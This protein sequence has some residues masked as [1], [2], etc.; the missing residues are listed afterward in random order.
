MQARPLPPYAGTAPEEDALHHGG[1]AQ[2]ARRRFPAGLEQP[3]DSFRFSVDALLLA[4]FA[5]RPSSYDAEHFV[6]LGTGCGVVS[7]AFLLLSENNTYGYGIDHDETL[8]AAAA[9]NAERLGL[10]KRF[11]PFHA[12]L[13]DKAALRTLRN[14]Q[15]TAD[16]VMA[17]PPWRLLGAG[18][19]PA[20]AARRAA[21]FGDAGTFPLFAEAASALLRQGGGFVCVVGAYRVADLFAALSPAR[22][23]PSLLR[24]VHKKRDSP[25]LFALVEA[26]KAIRP[27]LKVEAPLILYREDRI[28]TPE[29]LEFCPFLR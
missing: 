15:G 10:S 26:R 27:S 21:L 8:T 4:A 23:Q 7:L 22:L 12:D 16:L 11:T 28:F 13:H 6:D 20:R 14:K 19:L 18:R 25:A 1:E 9:R 5:A 3:E 2:L 29:S 17:N 24:F